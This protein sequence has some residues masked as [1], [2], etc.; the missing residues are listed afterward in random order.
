MHKSRSVMLLS[1]RI[2]LFLTS[3]IDV[4]CINLWRQQSVVAMEICLAV[5]DNIQNYWNFEL[6]GG[7]RNMWN[8]VLFAIKWYPQILWIL[9]IVRTWEKFSILGHKKNYTDFFQICPHNGPLL[10]Q[11]LSLCSFQ[12]SMGSKQ[13]IATYPV[14]I[15]KWSKLLHSFLSYLGFMAASNEQERLKHDGKSIPILALEFIFG[16]WLLG[17]N[18]SLHY[19]S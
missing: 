11:F 19:V 1:K 8:Y 16:Y 12:P 15:V 18:Y 2:V 6:R 17:G 10:V 7:G 9:S 4:F 13:W 3:V 14:I 5:I